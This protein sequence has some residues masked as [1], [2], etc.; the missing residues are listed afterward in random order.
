M[1]RPERKNVDYFPHVIKH[2]SKMQYLQAKY[3]NDGYATWFKIMEKL[4]SAEN[5]YLELN[6][7]LKIMFLASHCLVS[8]EVLLE[9]I[10]FLCAADWLHKKLWK[11]HKIICSPVFLSSINDAYKRRQNECITLEEIGLMYYNNPQNEVLT[12][13]INT[14]SKEEKKKEEKSKEEKSE[15]LIY[16]EHAVNIENLKSVL[17]SEEIWIEAICMNIENDWTPE[18]VKNR[19][20]AFIQRLKE[21]DEKFVNLKDAKDHFVNW[22]RK[23]F[24]KN[25]KTKISETNYEN[26]QI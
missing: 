26:M 8:N 2:G 1:A 10:E 7:D 25:D 17:E 19:F 12:G 9:I 23:K 22:S 16:N 14:Q 4:G 21:R 6:D 11:D 3:G 15:K 13:Y 18:I 20:P 24:K 5:H